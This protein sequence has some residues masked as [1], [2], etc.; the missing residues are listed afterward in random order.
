MGWAG[1]VCALPVTDYDG[2]KRGCD[3]RDSTGQTQVKC[4]TDAS[5]GILAY[6]LIMAHGVGFFAAAHLRFTRVES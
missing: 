5:F 2:R 1:L 4:A 3:L 6:S